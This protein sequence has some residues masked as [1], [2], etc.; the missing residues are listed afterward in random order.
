MNEKE[1]I[2]IASDTSFFGFCDNY[3]FK[4]KYKNKN[5]GDVIEVQV[6]K[7]IN[8]MRFET[9]S[10]IFTQASAAILANNFSKIYRQDLKKIIILIQKKLNGEQ[11]KIPVKIKELDFLINKK[12]K[13]R[14]DCI[15]LP[16]Y[17]VIRA[18]NA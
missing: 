10:C 8:Q 14:K 1:I 16:Y 5:C 11:V 18:L 15:T 3:E 9:N 13:N 7:D 17:A 12:N 6:N 2:K 4:A